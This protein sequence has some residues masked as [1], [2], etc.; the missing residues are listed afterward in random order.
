MASQPGRACNNG[1]AS[2]HQENTVAAT[3]RRAQRIC[4]ACRCCCKHCGMTDSICK[5]LVKA[6]CV[7]SHAAVCVADG[8]SS[9]YSS[10]PWPLGWRG[11]QQR[12]LPARHPG[13]AGRSNTSWCRQLMAAGHAGVCVI[14]LDRLLARL[15]I[16]SS[17][18]SSTLSVPSRFVIAAHILA[19]LQGVSCINQ[20]RTRRNLIHVG[21]QSETATE[22]ARGDCRSPLRQTLCREPRFLA[23][24]CDWHLCLA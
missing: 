4:P 5:R 6:Q 21:N 18:I 1:Q 8:G 22:A 13:A 23:Q 12:S 10:V 9:G 15:H 20:P 17:G 7:P 3:C 14:R 19:R 16:L 11:C 24:G 2:P